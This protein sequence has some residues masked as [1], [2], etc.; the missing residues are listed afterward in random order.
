M[1][2]KTYTAPTMSQ[3]MTL[4]RDELGDEAVIIS[5]FEDEGEVRVTAALDDQ[6]YEEVA[7]PGETLQLEIAK[8]LEYQ[9]IGNDLSSKLIASLSHEKTSSET[10]L[11]KALEK[12]FI[13]SGKPQFEAR[14]LPLLLIGPPGVGKTL[15]I[16]KLALLAGFESVPVHVIT[17]DVHKAGALEQMTSFAKALAMTLAT[18]NTTSELIK[19]V[20]RAPR[21]SF[22]LIDTPGC[23]PFCEQNL[24]ELTETILAIRVAPTLVI[25]G[26]ADL[27]EQADLVEV[28]SA[29]GAT[30]VIITRADLVRRL[31]GTLSA[32][33]E[34]KMKLMG[35]S[36]SPLVADGLMIL[37]P[38]AL[39]NLILTHGRASQEKMKVATQAAGGMK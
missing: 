30:K 13:F 28:F 1:K 24:R 9:G 19:E 4:I 2:I 22:L 7:N 29:I 10:L 33:H 39:A 17:T 25:P 32:L 36:T 26:G 12:H 5:S 14:S 15:T 18:A 31:G 8:A 37:N 11:A 21:G 35:L 6:P 16:A 38:Q 34:K 3:V 20:E 23:N 27:E